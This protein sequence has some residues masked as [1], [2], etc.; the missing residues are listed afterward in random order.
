MKIRI[1]NIGSI[2][3]WSRENNKVQTLTDVELLIDG[4]KISD[5]SH[6]IVNADQEINAEGALIIPGFIDSHTHPI[7]IVNRSN[8]FSL[9]V[10]GKT[11]DEIAK[12]GGGILA[13]IKNVINASEEQLLEESLGKINLFLSHGTTTIEA[14]S[15]YGL[16]LKD[17]VKSLRVIKKLNEISKLEIIPTF[18]GAHDFPPEFQ[19]N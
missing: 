4:D 19:N 7:F 18:L 8:A 15:G 16:T 1:H 17:E 11:Y 2:V 14:K 5:I 6:K 13:S 10:K 3:T 9:R 12:S